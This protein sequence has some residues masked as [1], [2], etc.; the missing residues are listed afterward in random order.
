MSPNL[1]TLFQRGDSPLANAV[2][3]QNF[4]IHICLSSVLYQGKGNVTL[5]AALL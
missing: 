4:A 5:R 1:V 3:V 2:I